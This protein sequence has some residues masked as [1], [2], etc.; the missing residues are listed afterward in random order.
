MVIHLWEMQLCW[1][2]LQVSQ[3]KSGIRTYKSCTFLIRNDKMIR[4]CISEPLK[5][6]L[7]TE[8]L[9]LWMESML[10]NSLTLE[11]HRITNI[12]SHISWLLWANNQMKFSARRQEPLRPR[13]WLPL[14][15]NG[16]KITP[17]TKADS[18]TTWITRLWKTYHRP[19]PSLSGQHNYQTR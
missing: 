16:H 10:S 18:P 2:D 7:E 1:T 13:T 19:R 11:V 12:A 3:T 8:R 15:K 5:L 9:T 6:Q 4:V 17:K 14:L